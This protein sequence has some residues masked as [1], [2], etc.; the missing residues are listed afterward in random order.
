[1]GL[2]TLLVNVVGVPLANHHLPRLTAQAAHVL[3]RE[4]RPISTA[5]MC[6]DCLTASCLHHRARKF[7][8]LLAWDNV[9][10]MPALWCMAARSAGNSE[11]VVHLGTS[12]AP[13]EKLVWHAVRQHLA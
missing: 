1:M 8:G 7:T 12:E 11:S 10:C 5:V 6:Y 3:Q 4:V 2:L 13:R 9:A